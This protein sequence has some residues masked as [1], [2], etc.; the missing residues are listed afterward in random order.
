[1]PTLTQE[2]TLVQLRSSAADVNQWEAFNS[3]S[4]HAPLPSL[5]TERAVFKEYFSAW[6]AQKYIL[7]L[8]LLW[9]L[10]PI[11]CGREESWSL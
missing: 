1:M 8:F 5:L 6:E 9:H 3:E 10:F 11:L 2:F 7:I 4:S